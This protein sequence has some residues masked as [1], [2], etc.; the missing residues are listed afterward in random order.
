VRAEYIFLSAGVWST[1][2]PHPRRVLRDRVGKE[3]CEPH[4]PLSGKNLF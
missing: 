1:G 4:K 2:V 3:E